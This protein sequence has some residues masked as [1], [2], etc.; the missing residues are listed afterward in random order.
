LTPDE[1]DAYLAGGLITTDIGDSGLGAGL[2]DAELAVQAAG[3]PAS[4]TALAAMPNAIRFDS[5]TDSINLTLKKLGPD[6]LTNVSPAVDASWL[7]VVPQTVDADGLGT[8][9]VNADR[10]NLSGG[11]HTATITIATAINTVV[12]P[13]QV[14]VLPDTSADAGFQYVVLMNTAFTQVVAQQP[15]VMQN[16]MYTFSLDGI[17]SGTYYLAAGTDLDNDGVVVEPGEAWGI[18]PSASNPTPITINHDINGLSFT[19]GFSTAPFADT[20]TNLSTSSDQ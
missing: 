9:R 1:V 17:A 6:T 12:V 7:T 4:P 15:A 18:Y 3:V 13:V 16:G 2:L 19:T 8:Y 5:T 14:E 20:I 10:A 11:L